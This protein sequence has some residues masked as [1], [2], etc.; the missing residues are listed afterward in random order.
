MGIFMSSSSKSSLNLLK[1]SWSTCNVICWGTIPN[2]A[3]GRRPYRAD[4]HRDLWQPWDMQ[5]VPLPQATC[6]CIAR[7]AAKHCCAVQ[8]ASTKTHAVGLPRKL[9]QAIAGS[10]HSSQ[11]TLTVLVMQSGAQMCTLQGPS[12]SSTSCWQMYCGPGPAWAVTEAMA[13]AAG[14]LSCSMQQCGTPCE[15]LDCPWHQAL[16]SHLH[17][18]QQLIRCK[19]ERS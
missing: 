16:G 19:V 17:S 1:K 4:Q 2:H 7:R 11:E 10:K 5:Q 14:W 15:L 13:T 9:S 18:A 6:R 3:G 8:I 12:K